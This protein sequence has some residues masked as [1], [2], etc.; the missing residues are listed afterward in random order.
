MPTKQKTL[1][2]L[3]AEIASLQLKVKDTREEAAKKEAAAKT[4]LAR[5]LGAMSLTDI[6]EHA[7]KTVPAHESS[8]GTRVGHDI[9]GIPMVVNGRSVVVNVSVKDVAATAA[10]RKKS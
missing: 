7:L 10:L 9:W 8:K 2:Q 6:V 3:K 5:K 1:A 4:A